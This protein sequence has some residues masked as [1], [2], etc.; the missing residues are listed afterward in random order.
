MGV[1]TTGEYS[2]KCTYSHLK[3]SN[4]QTVEQLPNQI[5]YKPKCVFP[6]M[7]LNINAKQSYHKVT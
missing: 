7:R 3:S 1:N 4:K 6:D 5:S 2:C